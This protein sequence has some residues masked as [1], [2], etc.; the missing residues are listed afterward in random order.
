MNQPTQDLRNIPKT[1]VS[2]RS[3][4]IKNR[5]RH[6]KFKM[7]TPNMFWPYIPLILRKHCAKS[8]LCCCGIIKL[9]KW[10]WKF[11]LETAIPMIPDV[12]QMPRCIENK[13][14]HQARY[15][16]QYQAQH[17]AASAIPNDC[18]RWWR[19]RPPAIFASIHREEEPLGRRSQR[20]LFC[21]C[22]SITTVISLITILFTILFCQYLSIAAVL[23]DIILDTCPSPHWSA[24]S[25]RQTLQLCTY[26]VIAL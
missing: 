13:A 20:Q 11:Q 19:S 16:A 26:L 25:Q 18:D 8:I 7:T 3:Y 2:D 9:S 10:S 17:Q 23:L 15:Q 22:L 14:Q 21:Q 1:S 4:Y 5:S 12:V 24:W 6:L